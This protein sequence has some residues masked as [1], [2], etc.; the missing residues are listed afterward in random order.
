MSRTRRSGSR[1]ADLATRLPSVSRAEQGRPAPRP[2]GT[3]PSI[4]P[5]A[6]CSYHTAATA[7]KQANPWNVFDVPCHN[8]LFVT[9][10]RAQGS[11]YEKGTST[12]TRTHVPDHTNGA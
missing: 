12:R 1:Q 10:D 8:T 2:D 3:R 4:W 6:Q 7:E 9:A 11:H 5:V